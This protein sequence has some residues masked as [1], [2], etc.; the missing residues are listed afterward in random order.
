MII[1]FEGPRLAG[2]TTLIGRVK[3]TL[4]D[5]GYP[6]QDWKDTRGEDPVSDMNAIL[7]EGIFTED[8]IWLLDRFH[9]SE[10]VNSKA[11]RR[12]SYPGSEWTF[13]EAGLQ[14]IDER[15]RDLNALIVL[16]TSSPWMI[17]KR[18]EKLRKKDLAGDSQRAQF[19]WLNTIGKT[20]CDMIHVINDRT[21]Q[22]DRLVGM[23][24]D[25]CVVWWSRYKP[26]EEAKA[27]EA[28]EKSMTETAE[29]LGGEV[30]D[31]GDSL[32]EQPEESESESE[33]PK[34][35]F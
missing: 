12:E 17:D 5:W 1:L 25:I 27:T 4:T 29:E 9:F 28:E 11:S 19:W 34:I 31:A 23:L 26:K 2:K 7:D 22:L 13:Y 21:D 10:W 3:K 16:V 20:R 6:V 24:A 32:D 15:M 30:K 18:M 14:Q 33:G 35:P 8:L